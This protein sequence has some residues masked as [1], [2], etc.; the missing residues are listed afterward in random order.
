[1]NIQCVYYGYILE[2]WYLV[3]EFR[4]QIT[5]TYSSKY[6]LVSFILNNLTLITIVILVFLLSKHDKSCDDI[7]EC[8]SR[9]AAP[10]GEWNWV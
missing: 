8:I 9:H 6:Y 7:V 2:I 3:S 4:I 5:S 1:M 10:S